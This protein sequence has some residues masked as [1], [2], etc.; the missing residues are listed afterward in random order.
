M[1]TTGSRQLVVTV[2]PGCGL[3]ESAL[4][5]SIS[6]LLVLFLIIL[7]ASSVLKISTCLGKNLHWN[8]DQKTDLF[9]KL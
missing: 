3:E 6:L 5:V 2:V 8:V 9:K 7:V 1:S 4:C